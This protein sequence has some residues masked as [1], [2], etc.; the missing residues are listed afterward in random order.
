MENVNLRRLR[1]RCG[2]LLASRLGCFL[3]AGRFVPHHQEKLG[4]PGEIDAFQ[5]FADMRRGCHTAVVR[6]TPVSYQI[7]LISVSP[8][9]LG[10]GKNLDECCDRR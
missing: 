8:S 2:G 6:F 3:P 9:A 5:Q 1:G 10:R 4:P 7:F